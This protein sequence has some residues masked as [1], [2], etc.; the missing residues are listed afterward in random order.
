MQIS[1]FNEVL[2][3]L[4]EIMK[5]KKQKIILL[6]DNTLVHLILNETQEKLDNVDVKFLLLNIT[7]ELQLCDAEIIHSFKCH[8]K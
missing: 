2:L 3:K 4:N 6:I 5:L 7:T 1:I 8:Y